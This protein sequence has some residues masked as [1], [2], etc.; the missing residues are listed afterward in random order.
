MAV[1]PIDRL[2]VLADKH[3]LMS[4]A[5]QLALITAAVAC[6]S[7]PE[8]FVQFLDTFDEELAAS[9]PQ[10]DSAT[11]PQMDS[12]PPPAEAPP[13]ATP[14]ASSPV[15]ELENFFERDL[16]K[17]AFGP[18]TACITTRASSDGAEPPEVYVEADV[19]GASYKLIA[20]HLSEGKPFDGHAV[21]EIIGGWTC[22][23]DDGAVAAIAIANVPDTGP[24]VDAFIVLP[25][26]APANWPNPSLPPI[27]TLDNEFVF[28]YPDGKVTRIK[29]VP[30]Y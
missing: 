14:T 30:T 8:A 11:A 7:T 21:G 20:E 19:D 29:L 9:P 27:T 17:C 6:G 26:D 10:M 13:P 1:L 23:L 24:Y 5:E 12:A 18:L 4:A 22:A 2:V 28:K 15:A 16:S 3:N 25:K